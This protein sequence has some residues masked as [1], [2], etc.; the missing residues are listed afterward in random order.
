MAIP[1]QP[2]AP[3]KQRHTLRTVLIIVGVVLALCCGGAVVGGFFIFRTVQQ[4]TGPARTTTDTFVTDL[5]SG[6]SA[7][8]YDRLCASTQRVFTRE[9]FA[10]GLNQQ[11]KVRSHQI[12]GVNVSNVNGQVS[13][14][15][16]ARLTLETGFVDKHTFTLVKEDGR[17]KVCGQPY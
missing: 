13:G 9:A 8:A 14:T 5:E 11:P 7:A 1:I 4:A 6:D 10:Q 16:T 12:D 17:W 3:P 15:V 2:P